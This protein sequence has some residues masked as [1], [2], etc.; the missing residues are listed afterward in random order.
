M[1]ATNLQILRERLPEG[2]VIEETR[3]PECGGPM[4]SRL[5]RATN[6]RFWGCQQYPKCNGTRDTDGR[7]KAERQQACGE[8]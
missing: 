6:Q 7:S 5:N 1:A 4:V 8:D 2:I 3:C